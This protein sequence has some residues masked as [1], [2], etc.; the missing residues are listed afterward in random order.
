MKYKLLKDTVT[1]PAGSIYK[2]QYFIGWREER[3]ALTSELGKESLLL[4][5]YSA[6]EVEG[7]PE[8]FKSIDVRWKPEK[9]EAY[10]TFDMDGKYRHLTSWQNSYSDINRYDNNA[11]FKHKYEVD[12]ALA[13]IKKTLFDYQ[14][15]L[16]TL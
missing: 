11:V 7:N 4:N 8:W 6:G 13:R 9:G 14:K 12:H 10:W 16:E 1:A 2:K 3:Y 15:E 5:T